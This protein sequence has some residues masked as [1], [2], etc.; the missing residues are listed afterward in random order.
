MKQVQVFGCDDVRLVDVAEPECGPDDVLVDVAACGICGS[1]L[2]YIRSG[3]PMGPTGQ[4]MSLGHEFAG[5]IAAKGSQ[6]GAWAVGQA[7]VVNPLAVA[8]L[9]GNGGPEGAFAPKVRVRSA[10]VPDTLFALPDSVP[11]ERGALAEPLAVAFHAVSQGAAGP[12]TRAVVLG[13]GPIGLGC[14]IGLKRAC[15]RDVVVIDRAALRREAASRLGADVTYAAMDESFWQ[16]L[17][18]RHGSAPFFGMPLPATDLFIDCSGSTALVEAALGRSAPGA[19]LV[20]T[21]VYSQPAALDLTLVMAKELVLRGA[22]AYGDSFRDAIE[23]LARDGDALATYV[24]DRV[25]LSRFDEALA[26]ARPG[27]RDQGD[28]DTRLGPGRCEDRSTDTACRCCRSWRCSCWSWPAAA[29]CHSTRR[30]SGISYSGSRCRISASVSARRA[31]FSRRGV[32]M[33]GRA[34]DLAGDEPIVRLEVSR[35]VAG[36]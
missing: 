21:A 15:V 22:F 25:P 27:P 5:R 36:R 14:V 13:A 28:R 1:D 19:R 32:V 7:V 4:P 26:R 33:S 31:D 20:L 11:L 16:G 30:R 24:S 35:A 8:N 9:I 12:Q 29:V 23:H 17:V 3:G 2:G 34:P 6:V 10:E 18:E